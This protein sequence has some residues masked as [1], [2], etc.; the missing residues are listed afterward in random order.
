MDGFFITTPIYY[1]NGQPHIG[2]AYTTIAADVAARWARLSGR[3]TRFLTGTDE[4]GQKVMQAAEAR[5]MTPRAHCDAL[6]EEWKAMMAGLGIGYDRFIRTTDAD[7]ERVVSATLQLL[8]DRDLLYKATY[9]G[10]Y[11]LADE[12]F[13][14]DKD[15]EEGKH[16]REKLVRLTEDNWWFR[17][18]SFQGALLDHISA[19]P[20]FLRPGNRRNE[21]LG[22]LRKPLNDLCI[23]RPRARMSWGIPL[24]FDRAFVTYVWFDALLNYLTGAGW[25][26]TD[27]QDGWDTWWP[28]DYQLI[29]KDILTTHAVYWTTMLLALQQ[30]CAPN[31]RPAL[32]KTLFAHG[33]WTVA[34][35][36][37]SK[38]VGN[39]IDVTGLVGA[40]GVDA[41][42]YF[43][44]R[45]IAFGADGGFSYDGFMSRY[46]VDLAND[47]GNLAHRG[48]SM[49]S[50]WLGG[51]VPDR[52]AWGPAEEAL[53][54][55]AETT[56]R[57][58]AERM[59]RL[60]FQDAL[61]AVFDLVG[62]GNKYVDTEAPWALNK[63]G[64]VERL[65]A[66]QRATLEVCGL[67]ALLLAPVMP[68]KMV[69]LCG[70]LG[71]DPATRAVAGLDLLRTGAPITF[72]DPLFPR[73]RELPESLAAAAPATLPRPRSPSMSEPVVPPNPAVA[74]P[75]PAPAPSEIVYDD[76]AKIQ[77]RTGKVMEAT[78]HPNA[79][80][81]IV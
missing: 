42:R 71:L 66:V 40:F 2:H 9:E 69:E 45:E 44:L 12:V 68:G 47:F 60:E 26:P 70:R 39:T 1:L 41:A 14:T 18:G 52:G 58:F 49:T 67:A 30:V 3:P 11:H 51:V 72:G 74:A 27:P 8:K 50:M 19:N 62:A 65:K 54:A 77:L 4:H 57:T 6:A 64:N 59:D 80:K 38:S 34:G 33:W 36:K 5:G 29:G 15:V 7:H 81:L 31:A 73:I 21:V 61:Q 79:D 46:N 23:S 13:V 63:A 32:P 43:F 53:V 10:W 22:F 35:E 48:T 16:D 24:P 17:M 75:A 55:R 25:H 56:V 78:K 28:A 20:D 37:M 76:F